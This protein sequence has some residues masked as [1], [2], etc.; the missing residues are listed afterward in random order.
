MKKLILILMV[1]GLVSTINVFAGEMEKAKC[2]PDEYK[3]MITKKVENHGMIGVDGK[4]DKEKKGL[5]I[6]S[7]FEGSNAEKA[8]LQKGDVLTKIN[9]IAM[10]DKKGAKAD[11]ENRTP[12][13]TV[14]V[15]V[16]RNGEE[17][18]MNVELIPYPQKLI[19]MQVKKYTQKYHKDEM[20]MKKMKKM[21]KFKHTPEEYREM[22]MKKVGKRGMIGVDGKWNEEKKGL[23]IESFI[24]G[25]NAEKAGLQKGDI[26]MKVNGI[27]MD[28]K[29]G[30]KAD[31]KNR[32]P[33]KTVPVVVDREGKEMTMNVELTPYPQKL[34]DM[35]VKKY[36]EKYEKFQMKMKEKQMKKEERM[37]KKKEMMEKKKEMKEKPE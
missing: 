20:K 4:W 13:K 35:H 15:T 19:D 30:T 33:G 31:Y 11:W 5:V 29:K 28:D 6:K 3:M 37:E 16:F 27:P 8:G 7:F 1:V 9:G 23:V 32:T 24:E 2:S 17:K 22:V 18:T 34:I 10:D 26:L 21:E 14:S 36:T 25:S 12:G